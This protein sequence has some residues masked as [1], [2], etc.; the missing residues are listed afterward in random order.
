M[1]GKLVTIERIKALNYRSFWTILIL[2]SVLIV[3]SYYVAG[4]FGAV[5]VDGE[6]V[7]LPQFGIYE[8]P[9]LWHYLTYISG[10][11]HYLP[12]LLVILLVTNDIQYGLWKQHVAEGLE[13]GELVGLKIL[14][15]TLLSAFATLLL[16]V[17]GLAFGLSGAPDVSLSIILE[18]AGFIV[19][20][21]VQVFAYMTIAFV[22]AV[23]VKKPA[24]AIILLLAYGI[25]VER[26]IRF[27]LPGEFSFYF[28]MAAFAGI[29]SN[30]YMSIIGAEVV[31]TPF[32]S[33]IYVSLAWI[34]LFLGGIYAFVRYKDV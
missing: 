24:Q 5:N 33:N 22:F 29:I 13:R 31:D 20:Y 32:I 7:D 34:A 9:M 25:I 28:P 18:R 19:G 11:L 3:L 10:F 1:I 27:S 21:F 8:F 17:T 6:Q 15:I 12:A 26:L 4:A 23:V 30:P 14:V 2:Y 16:V